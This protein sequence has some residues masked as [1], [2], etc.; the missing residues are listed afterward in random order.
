MPA[1]ATTWVLQRG[2]TPVYEQQLQA[3]RQRLFD[4]LAAGLGGLI[5][6]GFGVA[7]TILFFF[8]D[9]IATRDV[10]FIATIATFTLATVALRYWVPRIAKQ[11]PK[12]PGS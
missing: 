11:R 12:V 4:T 6:A 3:W 8:L 10:V 1:H 7:L 5:L 2:V 9:M